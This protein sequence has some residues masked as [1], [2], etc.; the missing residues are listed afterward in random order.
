[1]KKGHPANSTSKPKNPGRNCNCTCRSKKGR[2]QPRT[3]TDDTTRARPAGGAEQSRQEADHPKAGR[4]A[5]RPSHKLKLCERQVQARCLAK[6]RSHQATVAV[7]HAARGRASNRKPSAPRCGTPSEPPRFS[8]NDRSL[9]AA[10]DE[11]DRVGLLGGG[12]R[13]RPGEALAGRRSARALG[14]R[15]SVAGREKLPAGQRLPALA[16]ITRP[17][18]QTP[19][20]KLQVLESRAFQRNSGHPRPKS[21]K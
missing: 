19:R 4:P 21:A 10:D 18:R 6:L 17:A 16:E 15:G 20:R 12:P 2:E 3:T 9:Y 5:N 7:I 13:L 14:G 1:M 8:P 11:P